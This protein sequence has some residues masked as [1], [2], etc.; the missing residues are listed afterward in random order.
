LIVFVTTHSTR[1][2][3]RGLRTWKGAPRVVCRSYWELF[4]RRTVPAA[5]YILTDF[6][7]LGPWE[8]ELASHLY[9][10]LKDAG[11]Q[12]LNNPALHLPRHAL[13]QRLRMQGLNAIHSW[14]PVLDESPDR[15]PVFLRTQAAHRG[16][17]TELLH[18]ADE[19]QA[20]LDDALAKGHPLNDL[21]F[22]EYAAEP[23]AEGLFRKFSAF[24]IGEAVL[25]WL[26]VHS[27]HWV[28]KFNAYGQVSDALY[29]EEVARFTDD[30]YADWVTQV[31]KTAGIDYGRLDFGVVGGVPQAY[32][33]NTNPW[34][35]SARPG[36]RDGERLEAPK[37]A[38][39]LYMKALHDIDAPDVRGRVRLDHGPLKGQR[40]KDLKWLWTRRWNP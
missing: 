22:V 20:A 23:L 30:P 21:L 34:L 29:A 15:F 28:G 12:V 35:G 2:T 14:S 39:S 25:P 33:I 37:T 6:D 16:A 32:E 18:T 36:A 31:F 1:G 7:R 24:R 3:H 26:T 5:T 8:L 10:A 11:A 9:L 4:R 40:R 19:A 27:T 17:L 38:G 13:L